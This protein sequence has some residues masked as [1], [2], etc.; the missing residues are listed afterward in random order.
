L[1]ISYEYIP[2]RGGDD[3]DSDSSDSDSDED[4]ILYKFSREQLTDDVLHS[5]EEA[6]L[7]EF[8]ERSR[9]PA[10]VGIVTVSNIHLRNLKATTL[11]FTSL[12]PYVEVSLLGKSKRTKAQ[13]GTTLPHFPETFSFVVRDPETVKLR[14]VVRNKKKISVREARILGHIDIPLSDVVE[15]GGLR[16]QEYL[17]DGSTTECYVSLKISLSSSFQD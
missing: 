12:K 14:V 4:D 2:V 6:L 16:E 7:H 13:P 17:L 1:Q 9:P 10:S 11:L 3:S 5:E 8:P 15:N